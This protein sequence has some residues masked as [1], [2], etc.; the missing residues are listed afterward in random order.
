M[1]IQAAIV[2]FALLHL[3]FS[4]RVSRNAS[5][6]FAI[7][8]RWFRWAFLALLSSGTM[9]V[10]GWPGY[11][12]PVLL[13]V[14]ILGWFLIETG[15][16]WLMISTLSR[17]ELPL[18]PAFEENE[19]A[20]EWPSSP[21]FIRLREF[22]QERNFSKKQALIS[23]L[24]EHTLMRAFV[25]ENQDQTIRIQIL[26]FPN[27]S[28]NLAVAFSCTS[29]TTAGS[30]LVTDN[31]F[32]PF[33]GFYPE[34]WDLERR[35]WTRSLEKLLQ[36]HF[37]RMDAASNP[38]TPF[39]VLPLEQI[40]EDQ[41]TVEQLNRDLGFLFSHVDEVDNGRL[42]PAGKAR[43]WQEVWTLAYLGRPIRYN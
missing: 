32:L 6:I 20:D 29:I 7:F 9:Y 16:N 2:V 37:E 21:S 42:T 28:G 17:S 19:Q 43:V 36:R 30:V 13:S 41:R 38:F 22:L 33:G 39:V 25:Y 23:K 3:F 18:F 15:Y 34:N 5:P 10:L 12:F 27:A 8:G 11:S 26:L 31:I 24:G 4:W 40:N 1:L 35:P 14:S